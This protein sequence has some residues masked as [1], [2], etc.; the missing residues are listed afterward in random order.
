MTSENNNNNSVKN[1]KLNKQQ[2]QQNNQSS[3]SIFEGEE[4]KPVYIPQKDLAAAELFNVTND[5]IKSLS[6]TAAGE[7]ELRSEL[8]VIFSRYLKDNDYDR[9]RLDISDFM[10][11]RF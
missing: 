6:D 11:L 5:L 10:S 2:Q 9:Y 4:S 3:N 1:V 8:K 7:F